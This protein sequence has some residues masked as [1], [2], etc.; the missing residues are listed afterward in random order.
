ME[1]TVYIERNVLFLA[2]SCIHNAPAAYVVWA[3]YNKALSVTVML[4]VTNQQPSTNMD[5]CKQCPYCPYRGSRLAHIGPNMDQH[6]HLFF[7][8]FS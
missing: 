3:N 4:I 1:E 8:A 5:V 2:L 7:R 6:G